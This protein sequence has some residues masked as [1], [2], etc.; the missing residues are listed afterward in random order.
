MDERV[1]KSCWGITA[2]AVVGFAG[3]MFIIYLAGTS[4]TAT[5]VAA[6]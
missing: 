3:L 2:W 4:G 6:G 5:V 1:Q